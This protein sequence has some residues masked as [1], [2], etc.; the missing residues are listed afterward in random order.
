MFTRIVA[1]LTRL[2]TRRPQ[3]PLARRFNAVLC[4]V[5][6]IGSITAVAGATAGTRQADPGSFSLRVDA[7]AEAIVTGTVAATEVT[8]DEF[9]AIWTIATVSPTQIERGQQTGGAWRIA[10]PG[11]TDPATGNWAIAS[12]AAEL[13]TGDVARLALT[14]TPDG[15]SLGD[16]LWLVVMG[17]QGTQLVSTAAGTAGRFA[18]NTPLILWDF[19]SAVP[20]RTNP[21]VDTQLHPDATAIIQRGF[22]TMQ[23]D[24]G[25][26]IAWTYVGTSSSLGGS[27]PTD[28]SGPM[29]N[30]VYAGPAGGLVGYMQ[31]TGTPA[32]ATGFRIVIEPNVVVFNNLGQAVTLDWIDGVAP[33][34]VN[35]LNLQT[36]VMHE[37]GHVVGLAHPGVPGNVMSASQIPGTD[38]AVY[39]ADDLAGFASLYPAQNPGGGLGTCA[40]PGPGAIVGT[41]GANTLTGTAG[42]DLIVGLGGNDVIAGGGGDDIICGGSG[43][44]TIFGQA[45]ND[46]IQG[47][48]GN[49]KL[50][51]GDGN[52]V[53]V[54]GNGADDLNGG[55]GNDNVDGGPGNDSVVRG[56]TGDD[57]VSGGTGNDALVSGNGGRD[58]VAGG[59]GADQLLGG[60]RPDVLLGGAG[61]DLLR[62]NGGADSMFGE[63]GNDDLL[64]GGQPDA[65]LDGGAGSDV[66]NGQAELT[67]SGAVRSCETSLNFVP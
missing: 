55:R 20:Y 36:T 8:T 59:D 34:G 53:L 58:T 23:N 15:F 4:V 66:C 61:N 65:V 7:L 22:Q 39:S 67:A 40:A 31:L 10:I 9:G 29:D 1:D 46:T 41:N 51:G 42:N 30:H 14:S 32:G 21:N 44:D 37:L 64:G 16:D 54:G 52:D 12:H 63:G 19:A 25:S 13:S 47:D 28:F 35:A 3:S 17:A 48:D 26:D 38:P 60:P 5:A 24:S 33:V 62:G 27:S 6:L 18:L 50:R 45:G 11:G 2:R 49:D 57:S 56:G 43:D